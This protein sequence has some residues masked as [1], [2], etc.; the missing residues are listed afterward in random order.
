MS[1]EVV[2]TGL[3][4]DCS[5]GES[6]Q[7][8]MNR[9]VASILNA[10]ELPFSMMASLFSYFLLLIGWRI[11]KN[12]ALSLYDRFDDFVTQGGFFEIGELEQAQYCLLEGK[13]G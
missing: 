13:I 4:L 3:V 2:S 11:A 1:V 12:D 10:K 5:L 6:L 9:H 7:L 8:L